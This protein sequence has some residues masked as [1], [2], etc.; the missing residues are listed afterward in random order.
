M[1]DPLRTDIRTARYPVGMAVRKVSV[2]LDEAAYRAAQAAAG[3]AGISLSAWLSRAAEHA[4]GIED[5]LRAVA[6]YEAEYGAFS[7]DDLRQADAL[8]D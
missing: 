7:E 1:A 8:L 2:S 3:A 4:A 5:G 6:E